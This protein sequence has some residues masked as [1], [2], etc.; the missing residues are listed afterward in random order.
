MKIETYEKAPSVM[1]GA[2]LLSKFDNL[3]WI[4]TVMFAPDKVYEH[5]AVDSFVM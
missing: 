4:L 2:L 5:K 3:I 1:V